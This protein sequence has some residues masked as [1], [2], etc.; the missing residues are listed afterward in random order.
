MSKSVNLV[1]QSIE[2]TNIEIAL[3][4]IKSQN[5]WQSQNSSG[6]L[7]ESAATANNGKT[8]RLFVAISHSYL[9]ALPAY[10]H[11]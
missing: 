3:Y 9:H 10:R 4:K 7:K 8:D 1:E 6:D 11:P 5:V 2:L